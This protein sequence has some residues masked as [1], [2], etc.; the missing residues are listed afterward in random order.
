MSRSHSDRFTLTVV[1]AQ[2]SACGVVRST[3][4]GRHGGGFVQPTRNRLDG[5]VGRLKSAPLLALSNRPTSSSKFPRAYM[6]GRAYACAC[7]VP[8]SLL[9]TSKVFVFP[10]DKVRRLD[11][12][13]NSK[14]FSRPTSPSNHEMN[15]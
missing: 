5:K 12:F 9:V 3:G 7:V 6:R 1:V 8:P 2:G 13:S 14:G 15:G 11:G 10:L 4:K